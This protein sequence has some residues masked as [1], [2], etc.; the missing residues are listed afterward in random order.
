MSLP[1]L[2]YLARTHGTEVEAN[3]TFFK[4]L[5]KLIPGESED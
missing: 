3:G 5:A 4:S 1:R 2:T